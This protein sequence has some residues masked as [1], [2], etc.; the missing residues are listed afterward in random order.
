MDWRAFWNGRHSIYVNDRHRTVHYTRVADDIIA[1]LPRADAI[2][3]D[4]GCGEALHAEIVAAKAARL[5]LAEPAPGV[6]A[7][8][9]ARFGNDSRI[10]VIST[11]DTAALPDASNDLVVMHSVAQYLSGE[12][13]DA[14]LRKIRRLVKPAGLF[15]LG[16]IVPPGTP[17]STDA[18]ALLRFGWADG[19]FVPAFVSLVRTVFSPYWNLRKSLG[20]ARYSEAGM[21]DRLAA[22]GFA[23]TRAPRNIGHN[24]ARMTFVCRAV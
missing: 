15:V 24:Q 14:V 3:L 12:E 10:A 7:R 21:R 8:L 23:A 4:Y 17:A 13:L 5:I 1:M 19:F 16:D 9:S 11:E 20:L 6:R 2:V 22:A 18:L